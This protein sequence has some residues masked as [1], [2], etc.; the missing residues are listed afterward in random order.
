VILYEQGY[1]AEYGYPADLTL[2][3][4]ARGLDG[5]EIAGELETLYAIPVQIS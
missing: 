4:V 2:L 1:K 3:E 5:D